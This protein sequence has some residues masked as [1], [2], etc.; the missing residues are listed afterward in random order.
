[1]SLHRIV[2]AALLLAALTVATPR[3]QAQPVMAQWAAVK[4]KAAALR[5]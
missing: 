5:P 2:L 4:A 3:A 1:M